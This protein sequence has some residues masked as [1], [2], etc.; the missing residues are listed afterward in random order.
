MHKLTVTGVKCALKTFPESAPALLPAVSD[1]QVG[2][3]VEAV[4]LAAAEVADRE[5]V[6][7]VAEE[8]DNILG[9]IA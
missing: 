8:E 4:L 7:V 9:F 3:E 5:A 6:E 2:A 1:H